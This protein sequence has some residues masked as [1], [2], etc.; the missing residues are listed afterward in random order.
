[1]CMAMFNGQL[2]TCII[3][4]STDNFQRL[5]YRIYRQGLNFQGRLFL[6]RKNQRINFKITSSQRTTFSANYPK[7]GPKKVNLRRL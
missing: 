6:A 1:M 3:G 4:L 7:D 5:Y 2:T